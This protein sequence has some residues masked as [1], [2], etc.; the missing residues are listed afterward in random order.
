MKI[1]F[2]FFVT[3]MDLWY[4]TCTVE[5][6]NSMCTKVYL[7]K[8]GKNKLPVDN[9]EYFNLGKSKPHK[10]LNSNKFDLHYHK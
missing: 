4:Y 3:H 8:L 7:K 10:S 2:M 6:G 1:C 5:S 9:L